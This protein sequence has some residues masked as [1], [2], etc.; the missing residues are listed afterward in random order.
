MMLGAILCMDYAAIGCLLSAMFDSSTVVFLLF[1]QGYFHTSL[2]WRHLWII[3]LVI[4]ALIL[5]T[6]FFFI[7]ARFGGQEGA[8]L[9]VRASHTDDHHHN[10]PQKGERRDEDERGNAPPPTFNRSVS[11]GDLK[12]RGTQ[13]GNVK[14]EKA[15]ITFRS[16]VMTPGWWFTLIFMVTHNT[17]VNWIFLTMNQQ[18]KAQDVDPWYG[19]LYSFSLPFGFIGI[20]VTAYLIDRKPEAWA[21]TWVNLI[22][23]TMGITSLFLSSLVPFILCFFC[24]VIVKQAM[25]GLFFSHV[26]RV[27]GYTHFG[28]H[29][30]LVQFCIAI[31]G[32]S[33]YAIL[34][35]HLLLTTHR[36]QHKVSFDL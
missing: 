2:T 29:C 21:F 23:L 14:R 9:T 3:Y 8:G 17:H 30:G 31:M 32:L 20:P 22:Y 33:N 10:N 11:S 18:L 25:Y 27:F 5:I 15:P 34:L 36:H 35:L 1:Q 7:P 4:L 12:K 16:Q 19:E 24:V 26:G 28:K 6:A 13:S